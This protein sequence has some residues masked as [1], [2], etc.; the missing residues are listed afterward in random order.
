MT[1]HKILHNSLLPLEGILSKSTL[2]GSWFFTVK[3]HRYGW[4]VVCRS[5]LDGLVKSLDPKTK[6][7]FKYK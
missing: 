2:Q 6:I 5:N 7:A 1:R 4:V 3:G